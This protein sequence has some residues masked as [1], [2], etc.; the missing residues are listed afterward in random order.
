MQC[1]YCNLIELSPQNNVKFK[2]KHVQKPNMILLSSFIFISG[3]N[4]PIYDVF[5]CKLEFTAP[6]F[7]LLVFLMNLVTICLDDVFAYS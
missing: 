5:S 7:F 3:K 4:L 6:A 1:Y 2:Q